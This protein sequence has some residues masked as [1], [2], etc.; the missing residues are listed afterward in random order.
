MGC[1]PSYCC[2][3]DPVEVW[4]TTKRPG[5]TRD[6]VRKAVIRLTVSKATTISSTT[7]PKKSSDA[8]TWFTTE[9]KPYLQTTKTEP[10]TSTLWIGSPLPV[11]T[12][13]N[14]VFY[15][16]SEST[17]ISS[18]KVTP[19]VPFEPTTE[20]SKQESV[21]TDDVIFANASL[22]PFFTSEETLSLASLLQFF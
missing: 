21:S 7:A 14:A 19:R 15:A 2:F 18:A 1:T 20:H 8:S 22:G 11:A 17:H 9:E 6:A 5:Y 3:E 4:I 10:F 16:T 13:E 12:T